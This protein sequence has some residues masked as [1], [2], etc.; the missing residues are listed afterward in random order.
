[1]ATLSTHV[2]DTSL[3]IPADGVGVTLTTVAGRV[4]EE[5]RTDTDG[6][7]GHLGGDLEPGDYTLRFGTG[8]YLT[9]AGA[10]AFYPE[11]VITF[12][13]A[14]DE[15]HHVPLLLSPFGYSTYRGS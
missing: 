12:T 1:M 2:L 13:I 10:T 4:L 5:G 8:D 3:G 9:H 7:I 14:A 11:V 15:H 6:R